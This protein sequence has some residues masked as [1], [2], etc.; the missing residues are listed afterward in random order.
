MLLA[1]LAPKYGTAR[2]NA[3]QLLVVG[4]ICFVP[5]LLQGGYDF[6][7][8]AWAAAVYTAISSSAIAF[9][10][11]VW[12]QRRVGPT[13]TSLLLMV[14][15]VAAALIGV[16]AGDHL[17][18]TGGTGAALILLGIACAELGPLMRPRALTAQ[19]IE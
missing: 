6:T 1:D 19:S 2:L 10:L 16:F 15:P 7:A 12:G 9:A 18:W 13:R 14:E 4:A 8:K 5:G 11:Q 3:V 17:G